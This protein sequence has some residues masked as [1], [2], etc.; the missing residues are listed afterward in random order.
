VNAR[1]DAD[2]A[3]VGASVAGCASAILFAQMGCRVAVF[4]QKSL[5]EAGH[6]KR[7]CTHFIQPSALP[8]LDRLGL[9][10]LRQPPHSMQTQAMFMTDGGIIDDAHA[11]GGDGAYALNLERSVLDPALRAAACA[12]G[13]QLVDDCGI[14]DVQRTEHGW[15]L[16]DG[17]GAVQCRARLLVGAD[18]RQSRLARQLDAPL[19]HKPND[20][21]AVFG[22]FA[23]I[24]CPPQRRSLFILH[25][26]EMAFVYP[27]AH[28]RTLL[29][30]YIGK[31][32]ARRWRSGGATLAELLAFIKTLPGAPDL[33]GAVA[34]SDVLGYVDY[35]NQVRA[36]VHQSVALV[37]DAALSLDPMSGVGCAFALT[38]AR[39]LAD[40]FSDWDRS[41]TGMEQ[42]LGAYARSYEATIAPH[43]AGICADSLGGK[44][45]DAQRRAY[46]QI[47]ADQALR[48]AYLALTGRMILPAV[49]Q[50]AFLR[51]S[52]VHRKAAA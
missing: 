3:I 7:L 10:W 52:L 49:F 5:A 28:G 19:E 6:Y 41:A 15:E 16:R 36:P 45:H 44:N 48:P 18:G 4:E 13:V 12:Q 17:A 23:G 8:V 32:R 37:G 1:A 20:R 11:Y 43:I 26:G 2:V 33:D 34:K 30:V 42:A 14:A 50:R 9:G 29:S 22:Y 51:S 47:G 21:A 25:E 24:A 38:G 39:L 35:P 27:L 31:E 40:A 46:Q